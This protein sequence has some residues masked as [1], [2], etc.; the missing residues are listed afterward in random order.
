VKRARLRRSLLGGAYGLYTVV[1]WRLLRAVTL[2]VRILLV[3]D[4]CVLL[5][6]HSYQ[7]GWNFP[8]GGIKVGETV[9]EAACREAAEEA[10]AIV[11]DEPWLLGVYANFAA[12]KSDHVAVVVSESWSLTEPTD[13]WEI[14]AR[15]LYAV[16]A[17]PHDLP[18]WVRDRIEE[19]VR[20]RD[21]GYPP[22]SARKLWQD[23]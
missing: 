11:R 17:L 3:Q 13:R 21:G 8:G 14:E 6:R 20:L 19:C 12:G 10:G 16:D 23:R 2:G 18:H 9:A 4:G 1:R 22:P 5:I 7:S 15:V